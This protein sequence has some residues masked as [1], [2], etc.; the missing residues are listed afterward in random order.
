MPLEV[1][2]VTSPSPKVHVGSLSSGIH[3][4][5]KVPLNALGAGG[6]DELRSDSPLFVQQDSVQCLRRLADV[7]CR[8]AAVGWRPGPGTTGSAAL[9]ASVCLRQPTLRGATKGRVPDSL[10]V[11]LG[12]CLCSSPADFLLAVRVGVG[13]S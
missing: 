12:F 2:P 13:G 5:G 9:S 10:F 7:T 4:D 1:P 11:A 8:L 6:G 3:P